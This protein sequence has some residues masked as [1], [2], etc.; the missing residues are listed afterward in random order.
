MSEIDKM[1]LGH[2]V[3]EERQACRVFMARLLHRLCAYKGKVEIMDRTPEGFVAGYAG[4][5]QIFDSEVADDPHGAACALTQFVT[6]ELLDQL[7][8][9]EDVAT[10]VLEGLGLL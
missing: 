6:Q 4:L 10:K 1:M 8:D 3:D 9:D 7:P 2:M 5:R